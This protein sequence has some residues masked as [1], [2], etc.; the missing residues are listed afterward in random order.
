MNLPST[1]NSLPTKALDFIFKFC[2]WH[3]LML[4]LDIAFYTPYM[5]SK[6]CIMNWKGRL[7]HCQAAVLTE[8]E[9]SKY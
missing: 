5:P 3:D 8:R 2:Q 1:Y 4:G 7:I 6:I 9:K